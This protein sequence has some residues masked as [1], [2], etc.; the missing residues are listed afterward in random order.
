MAAWLLWLWGHGRDS[1]AMLVE[2]EGG[3]SWCLSSFALVIRR[4]CAEK[5]LRKHS[6]G[7][8]HEATDCFVGSTN[9]PRDGTLPLRGQ[10]E[11]IRA[12]QPGE[13]MASGRDKSSLQHLTGC[14]KEGTD[15]LAGSVAIGQGETV[16][17]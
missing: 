3:C 10:A 15:P 8:R 13:G 9:A 4:S 7:E 1:S 6:A 16:S 12:V 17:H 5:R 2:Q 14:K 11:G